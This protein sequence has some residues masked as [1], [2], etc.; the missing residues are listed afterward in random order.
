MTLDYPG[1]IQEVSSRLSSRFSEDIHLEVRGIVKNNDLKLDGLIISKEGNP[2]SPTLYLNPYYEDYSKG[3]GLDEICDNI[4][5]TYESCKLEC[6]LDPKMFSD[7][8]ALRERIVYR[9]VSVSQNSEYLKDVPFVPFLD[10]AIVFVISLAV[11]DKS[12][13]TVL[14]RKNHMLMWGVGSAE[15]MKAAIS[16]TKGLYPADIFTMESVLSRYVGEEE[17]KSLKD[18]PMLV[19]SNKQRLYGATVMLYPDFL[20]ELSEMVG[21][22]YYII[23]SSVHELIVLPKSYVGEESSLDMI[24]REVNHNEVPQEDILSNHA[25]LYDSKEKRIIG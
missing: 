6:R 2:I 9:L 23:P 20:R 8:S 12:N 17:A 13:A 22:D 7:F 5:G 18:C 1:F 3:L 4:I 11:D 21:E 10:L 25:Y 16:N 19:V 24:I 15:L 14:I